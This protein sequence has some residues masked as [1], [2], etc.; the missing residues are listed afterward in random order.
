MIEGVVAELCDVSVL[1]GMLQPAALGP[2][3]AELAR[4]ISIGPAR[5]TS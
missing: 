3:S 2:N 5:P 4:M 1:P